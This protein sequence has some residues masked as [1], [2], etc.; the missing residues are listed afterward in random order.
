LVQLAKENPA[1]Y[2]R[3]AT[4]F[5]IEA[6]RSSSSI[7]FMYAHII[8]GEKQYLAQGSRGV[9]SDLSNEEAT[10]FAPDVWKGGKTEL[11]KI[12]SAVYRSHEIQ[13]FVFSVAT[14]HNISLPPLEGHS[15]NLALS[16]T[17]LELRAQ[18][19]D[20]I[21]QNPG[22]WSEL[23]EPG[24][25]TFL[26]EIDVDKLPK[27]TPSFTKLEYGY[28]FLS[29]LNK[30]VVDISDIHNERLQSLSFVYFTM[31]PEFSFWG[32]SAELEG[33]MAAALLL[34]G[35]SIEIKNF[36]LLN[37]RLGLN[38]LISCWAIMKNQD[39]IDKARQETFIDSAQGYW[40]ELGLTERK[41]TIKMIATLAP[42]LFTELGTTFISQTYDF[43]LVQT[44]IQSLDEIDETSVSSTEAIVELLSVIPAEDVSKTL[45]EVLNHQ[46]LTDSISLV[47][48]LNSSRE[49]RLLA[50][51]YISDPETNSL[52]STLITNKNLLNSTLFEL[53]RRDISLA[54]GPQ[55]DVLLSFFGGSKVQPEIPDSLLAGATTNPS[56]E[57]ANLGHK[58][59]KKRDIL[60]KYWLDIAE[61]QMPLAIT[62][63]RDY[64]CSLTTQDLS[65]TLLL[66]LDSPVSAVR[67]MSLELLDTLREKID[68]PFVY[69]R[70]AESRDPVIRGRVAEEAL[71]S[72]WSDG[73]DLV[74]FDAELLVTLRRVRTARE[75]VMTR[76]DNQSAG[77]PLSPFVTPER[78]SAL[79]SL[80]RIGNSRDRE[81]AL[82]RLA[83]L[84]NAGHE[85]EE[86]T[87]S[88]V[89]G[90]K[91][92]V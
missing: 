2:L 89:T 50:W 44:F 77:L 53:S 74:D 20:Q 70:M 54:S 1:E 16:S 49:A 29:A 7:D 22:L 13:D 23:N 33:K 12:W 79:I 5:L 57:L 58:L 10:P 28:S 25:Q 85:I 80:A 71:L 82:S 19:V 75:N 24:W 21:A 37:K 69:S 4:G 65:S 84:K 17:K 27:L 18:T 34:S 87:L 61:T 36:D 45:D 11:S 14:S 55:V 41:N 46:E 68:T 90:G 83:Q 92:N 47:E 9:R 62:F 67:D 26:S 48:L 42:N 86:I 8:Y 78:I 31:E 73:E 56:I 40:K 51:S 15:I 30:V 38:A 60:S 81:W 3:I 52:A 43:E 66:G 91:Q 35:A 72:P 39:V 63:A 6:D 88:Y 64:L 59:L 32:R 76:F